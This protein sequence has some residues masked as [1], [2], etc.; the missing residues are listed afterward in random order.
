MI[1]EKSLN[2]ELPLPHPDNELRDD[3][4]RIRQSLIKIDGATQSLFS[5][6]ASDDVNL[7][8]VQEIV[9]VLKHAQAD[10]SDITSV[11]ATKAFASDVNAA[12]LSK[13]DKAEMEVKLS[14]KAT[15]FELASAQAN[16]NATITTG[17]SEAL[18]ISNYARTLMFT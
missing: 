8:S 16:I 10:I 2:L 13:A 5:L 4:V 17:L 14:E 6:V 12:L 3:V 18:A 9:A 7:D 1:D 11:L 15:K